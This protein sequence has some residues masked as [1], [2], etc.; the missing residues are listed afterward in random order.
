M[1]KAPDETGIAPQAC[2]LETGGHIDRD[3][4]LRFRFDG[5]TLTGHPGDTLASALLANGV[6]L[7][8]RSFKY[9]TPRGILAEGAEDPSGLVALGR[10]A[11]HEPNTRATMTTLTDGLEAR[12]QNAWPSLR[13]DAAALMRPLSAFMPVGFYYKTFQWPPQVWPLAEP[14]LRRM[15]GLGTSPRQPDPDTYE[16]RTAHCDV[17]VVGAGPAGLMAAW[18]ALA[19]GA[20]VI[21]AD[22]RASLGGCLLKERTVLND[23]PAA[24]WVQTVLGELTS[25]SRVTVLPATTVTGQHDHGFWLAAERIYDRPDTDPAAAGPRQR[26]WHIR[27]KQTVLATG[28]IERP[29][30]FAGNDRPGVMLAGSVRAYLNQYAVAPGHKAVVFASH[31][32]GYRT[33]LDL[34]AA[35]IPVAA[36][37][38]PRADVRGPLPDRVRALGVPVRDGYVIGDT[39]GTASGGLSA[40]SVHRYR[41]GGDM[42]SV[43]EW[44]DI[45]LLATSGGWN[46]TL[47]LH[48]HTGARPIWDAET[49]AFQPDPDRGPAWLA[50]ACG[51]LKPLDAVLLSGREAG[52]GA[53]E[54]AGLRLPEGGS[55][56]PTV[57]PD[58]PAQAT[59][60]TRRA[61]LWAVPK[62]AVANGKRFVDLQSDV[63][64]ED[65]A[66]A[67]REG[68]ESVEHLKRYTALGMGTDQ[69]KTSNV[70]GLTLLAAARHQP[71]PEVGTTTFRA[72]YTPI[73][74]GALAGTATGEQFAPVRRSPLHDVQAE[75]GAVFQ[76]TGLWLRPRFFPRDGETLAEAVQREVRTTRE[77]VGMVDVSF[78]G[79]IDIQGPDAA[80][81][82]NRVYVNGWTGLPVGKVRYG[83]MLREDGMVLDDGTTARLAEDHFAMTT[84]TANAGRVMEHLEHALQVYWPELDVRLVSTTDAWAAIAL[85]GPRSRQLLT[86]VT[87]LDVS[88]DALPFMGVATGDVCGIPARVFRISFSGELAYEINVPAGYGETLWRRLSQAGSALGLTPYGSEALGVMRI[89]KG[90]VAGP[91]L[92]GRT[93]PHDLGLGRMVSTKKSFIG[94]RLLERPALTDP[95][96]PRLVGLVPEDGR[97]RLL[98]GSQII[99][100]EHA[101]APPPI[102]RLGHISS[103]CSG[104]SVGHPVALGFL[105]GGLEQW[106]DQTVLVTYPLKGTQ[107]RARV[108]PP[109]FYDPEGSRQNA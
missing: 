51:G 10:G 65:V 95:D 24:D 60:G 99:A 18:A 49:L 77:R 98:A 29:L 1:T 71:I 104:P 55:P 85:A 86:F 81:F 61:A 67:H 73:T 53:A 57:A 106:A 32:E 58:D 23:A 40:V 93:T 45:D 87:D 46:P 92:D 78:L 21:L 90:H 94:H 89:E 84:T 9:H 7:V 76:A 35:G 6:R 38:D 107:V 37:V 19:A 54:A 108:V 88:N 63:T 105:T 69:G 91:E 70:T 50:G 79:K 31:D 62:P 8:A 20:R 82:L 42:V 59:A 64:V 3:R 56:C 96:R 15:A 72:P 28:A 66:L 80:E 13:W 11:R 39:R 100:V 22:E 34:V 97:T 83:L 12:S 17:L 109:Q 52:R 68:L 74:L 2:R 75:A 48:A 30:V 14:V 102:P 36:V 27:A 25:D 47:H 33:A 5:R 43:G 26:L 4:T 44:L 41:T 16:H 101:G 103:A